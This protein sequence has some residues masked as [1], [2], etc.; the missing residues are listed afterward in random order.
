MLAGEK[1]GPNFRTKD[2]VLNSCEHRQNIELQVVFM[3]DANQN[4]SRE[5]SNR[6]MLI[7]CESVFGIVCPGPGRDPNNLP[8]AVKIMFIYSHNV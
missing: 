5:F 4:Y 6:K 2:H 8:H 7:V 3:V 1:T